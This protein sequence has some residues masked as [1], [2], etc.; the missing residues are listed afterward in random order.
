LERRFA[1]HRI[2]L[3][4]NLSNLNETFLRFKSGL[5]E[6]LMRQPMSPG[7]AHLKSLVLIDRIVD[8]QATMLAYNDVYV[9][10][11]LMFL[12]ILPMGLFIKRQVK[13]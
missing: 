11:G 5:A 9:F 2:S 8:R 10:L 4:A 6:F 13:E 12:V 3:L 1:F 7:M